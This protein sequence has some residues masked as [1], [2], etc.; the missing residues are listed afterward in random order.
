M[1][2][3]RGIEDGLLH[4]FERKRPERALCGAPTGA[5]VEADAPTCEVCADLIS[6]NP[7][8]VVFEKG[9]SY[10]VEFRR[11]RMPGDRRGRPTPKM[12]MVGEYLRDTEDGEAHV[13]L[14]RGGFGP[15]SGHQ[16]VVPKKGVIKAKEVS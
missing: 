16:R 12:S 3:R 14:P 15:L 13:F 11:E 1:T 8:L 10:R 4:A 6:K 5:R 9:K 2:L 7:E